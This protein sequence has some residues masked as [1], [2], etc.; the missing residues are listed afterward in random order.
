MAH[1]SNNLVVQGMSGSLEK[2]ILLKHYG[3]ITLVTA[4]PDR[5]MVKITDSQKKENG[6]FRAAMAYAR[7]QMADPVAKAEYQ[8][9]AKGLQRAHNMAVA[10]FYHLPE[11]KS[12][13]L[14]QCNGHTNDPVSIVA[15]DILK[16]VKLTVAITDASGKLV[17]SGDAQKTGRWN[18]EYRLT[19]NYSTVEHLTV[20]VK[21]WD[22]PGNSAEYC[23][24]LKN[25][26]R[27]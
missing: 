3:N 11:I 2:K 15:V 18:W 12:I 17:E 10:D 21:A 16:V 24:A 5:S 26:E 20:K 7:S 13:D 23:E 27:G 14:A 22:K 1:V 9:I 8:A 19:G 4:F 25:K 6:R